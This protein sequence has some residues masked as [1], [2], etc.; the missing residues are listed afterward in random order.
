MLAPGRFEGVG[1][2]VVEGDQAKPVA[3]GGVVERLVREVLREVVLFVAL[4]QDQVRAESG[5]GGQKENGYLACVE[6]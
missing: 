4:H 2:Q 5:E 6:F 1:G 3:V